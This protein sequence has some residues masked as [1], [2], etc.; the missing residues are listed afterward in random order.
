MKYIVIVLSLFLSLGLNA[1]SLTQAE[2]NYANDLNQHSVLVGRL[3]PNIKRVYKFTATNDGT[4]D[5]YTTGSTDTYGYLYTPNSDDPIEEDDISSGINKNFSFKDLYVE[6]GKTYYIA[7]EGYA[8]NQTGYFRIKLETHYNAI[9][10]EAS[11][12]LWTTNQFSTYESR[13]RDLEIFWATSLKVTIYGSTENGYDF[14]TIKD[15]NGNVVKKLSGSINEEFVVDGSKITV[16][17]S[18]D[19]SVPSDGVTVV[20]GENDGVGFIPTSKRLDV[21]AL[22][23]GDY[24]FNIDG[25]DYSSIGCVPTTYAMMIDYYAKQRDNTNLNIRANINAL[26]QLYSDN[27]ILSHDLDGTSVNVGDERF[28]NLLS[29]Q[30]MAFSNWL[31]WIS[32]SLTLNRSSTQGWTYDTF[33]SNV[34]QNINQNKPIAVSVILFEIVD[35]W[36]GDYYQFVGGHHMLITGYSGENNLIINDTWAHQASTWEK[37]NFNSSYNVYNKDEDIVNASSYGI[38]TNITFKLGNYIAVARTHSASYNIPE[39]VTFYTY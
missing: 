11:P 21:L 5:I 23:Q 7:V 36:F 29:H 10:E 14:V 24:Q 22:K 13:E 39:R 8:N 38:N 12:I 18:S 6:K 4:V 32:Y 20:I 1:S 26:L 15:Q 31:S 2:K 25:V 9:N 28:V 33:I 30:N 35:G 27:D 17:L 16:M 34:K 19:G 37:T 3:S